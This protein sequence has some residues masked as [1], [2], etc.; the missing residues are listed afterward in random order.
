MSPSTD[1]FLS[2]WPLV[3]LALL[4]RCKH[5]TRPD[6]RT[7]LCALPLPVDATASAAGECA[8]PPPRGAVISWMFAALL[9][10]TAASG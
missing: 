7:R 2:G 9:N 6:Q 10:I 1:G 5:G 8:S 3:F 4:C